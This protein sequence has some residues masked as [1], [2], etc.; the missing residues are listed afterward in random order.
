MSCT[1]LS[2]RNI[3]QAV[4][5]NEPLMNIVPADGQL[6]IE[7]QVDSSEIGFIEIGQAAKVKVR[8]YDF[9]KYG[10]LAGKVERIAADATENPDDD[11]I[12]YVVTVRLDKSYLGANPGERTILPG[13]MVDVELKTGERTVLSYLTDRFVAAADAAF[14]EH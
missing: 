11:K 1:R 7:A 9:V 8:T 14:K 4:G 5:P 3:G 6:V 12:V 2:V 13:M 10:S